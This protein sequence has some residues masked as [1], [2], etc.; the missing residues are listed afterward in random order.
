M[1]DTLSLALGFLEGN[2]AKKGQLVTKRV[3]GFFGFFGTDE[4][5]GG[6]GFARAIPSW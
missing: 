3:F 1:Q 5:A 2:F 4:V 6:F